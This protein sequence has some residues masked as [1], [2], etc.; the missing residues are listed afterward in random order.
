MK[1]A[2]KWAKMLYQSDWSNI[3]KRKEKILNSGRDN[4][5]GAIDAR[6]AVRLYLRSAK[7][8]DKPSSLVNYYLADSASRV[9]INHMHIIEKL[10][11]FIVVKL[12][13]S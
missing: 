3:F 12:N 1:I 7:R 13:V 2:S 11:V 6:L 9:G 8:I 4:V 10:S 5:T